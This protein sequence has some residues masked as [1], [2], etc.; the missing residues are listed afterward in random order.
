MLSVKSLAKCERAPSVPQPLA[1]REVKCFSLLETPLP[2]ALSPAGRDPSKTKSRGGGRGIPLEVLIKSTTV[3]SRGSRGVRDRTEPT[4]PRIH[5]INTRNLVQ[6]SVLLDARIRTAEDSVLIL[7]TAYPLTQASC[8]SFTRYGPLVLTEVWL[9]PQRQK[10]P[11]MHMEHFIFSENEKRK[12][13][14]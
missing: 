12:I 1:R 8:K 10:G 5:G 9:L 11:R 3:L 7:Q 2:G 13:D 14:S 4:H 6:V